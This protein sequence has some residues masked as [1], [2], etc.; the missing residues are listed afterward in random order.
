V[1]DPPD[2]FDFTPEQQT[3]FAKLPAQSATTTD[4]ASSATLQPA[5]QERLRQID[6]QI[7]GR[8]TTETGELADAKA[9][10][11]QDDARAAQLDKDIAAQ[12]RAAADFAGHTPEM[13]ADR[14]R[15][16][17]P[18]MDEK[19]VT[20]L[21]MLVLAMGLIG[22]VASRG[23]WQGVAASLTGA[24]QGMVDGQKERAQRD[25]QLYETRFKEAIEHDKNTNKRFED[26][27]RSKQLSINAMIR[28]Y[29]NAALEHQRDAE[30]VASQ[31]RRLDQ[32]YSTTQANAR[33]IATVQ[34]Q[35]DRTGDTLRAAINTSPGGRQAALAEWGPGTKWLV[36][37]GLAYG[38]PKL[39]MALKSSYTTPEA[40]ATMEETAQF[41]RKNNIDPQAP[42]NAELSFH[43]TQTVLRNV[44]NRRIAVQRLTDSVQQIEHQIMVLTQKLNGQGM[45]AATATWQWMALHM[46]SDPEIVA[47]RTLM[48]TAATQYTEATTMPG[49][50]AQLHATVQ[51]D[52]LNRFNS[53]YTLEQTRKLFQAVNTD[54]G[55]VRKAL[56]RSTQETYAMQKSHSFSIPY[57]FFTHGHDGR[58]DAEERAIVNQV[59]APGNFPE[60]GYAHQPPP[61][62][63]PL[64]AAAAPPAA[65]APVATA[66]AAAAPKR[67]AAASSASSSRGKISDEAAAERYHP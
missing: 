45:P 19:Q 63:L 35:H 2:G 53:A 49:S 34:A 8:I 44:E 17:P 4:Q 67:A 60:N 7:Q 5:D 36:G 57:E 29:G 56:D 3:G 32:M 62:Y 33:A 51:Q 48:W 52:M 1:A 61:G 58:T 12:E 10:L 26:I 14:V 25:W 40:A 54:I 43:A 13:E 65:A 55:A 46:G 30:L 47:L 21:G 18:V 38:N 39:L 24:L 28:E 15:W 64:G 20:T 50:N 59:L 41:M 66:P 16:R 37:N 42:W 23:N 31:E 11:P 27:L 6:A 22:G 9:R